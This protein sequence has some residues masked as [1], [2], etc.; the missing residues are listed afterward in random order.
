MNTPLHTQK[1]R[2]TNKPL[3]AAQ[4]RALRFLLFT[5]PEPCLL[6]S[7]RRSTIIWLEEKGF[8]RQVVND[9][10]LITVEGRAII[11]MG[12]YMDFEADM[13]DLFVSV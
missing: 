10:W 13:I 4:V 1:R 7:T 2:T 8:I 9:R 6:Q 3:S 5:D 11:D 12:I